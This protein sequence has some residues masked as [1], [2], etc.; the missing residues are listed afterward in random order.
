MALPWLIGAAAVATVGYLASSSSSSSSSS[1]YE[2]EKEEAERREKRLKKQAFQRAK[3]DFKIK[4]GVKYKEGFET[5][6]NYNEIQNKI[7]KIEQEMKVLESY[8]L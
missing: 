5:T 2:E 8:S 6:E 1:D 4:W 3:N 7:I